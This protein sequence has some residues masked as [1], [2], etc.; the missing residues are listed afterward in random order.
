MPRH[1]EPHCGVAIHR[2]ERSVPMDCRVAAL[3]AMT[4]VVVSWAR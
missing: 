2:Q 3:L 1:R 4:D